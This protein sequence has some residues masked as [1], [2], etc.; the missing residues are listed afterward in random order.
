VIDIKRVHKLAAGKEAK[1]PR[2]S[3]WLDQI[4]PDVQMIERRDP[5]SQEEYS[6][7]EAGGLDAFA[8]LTFYIKFIVRRRRC[9]KR[10]SDRQ[11][12]LY[13]RLAR[14]VRVFARFMSEPEPPD[15]LSKMPYPGSG[16]FR[17]LLETTNRR[18]AAM[19]GRIDINSQDIDKLG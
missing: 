2:L 18:I 19:E 17:R 8:L 4:E 1:E 11:L 14:V 13:Y 9:T 3:E 6:R 16:S 15:G 5:L 7:L 10:L 12:E